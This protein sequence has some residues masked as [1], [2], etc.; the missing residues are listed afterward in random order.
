MK[1]VWEWLNLLSAS[2]KKDE[3]PKVFVILQREIG[4]PPSIEIHLKLAR[5]PIQRSLAVACSS[6]LLG[7]GLLMISR[8]FQLLRA[9]RRCGIAAVGLS[10]PVVST[11]RQGS[12]NQC[13]GTKLDHK[14]SEPCTCA[15]WAW[16][17]D[18]CDHVT[19]CN[20]SELDC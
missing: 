6:S 2:S 7:C 10:H 4:D 16:K 18:N 19:M 17:C 13:M 8:A 20:R 9:M 15:N 14:Q 12:G 1:S 3:H 11:A 5:S